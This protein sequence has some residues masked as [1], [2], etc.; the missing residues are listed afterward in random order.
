MTINSGP[1][2]YEA[3]YHTPRGAWV[4]AAE[5]SLMM[6]LLR[7]VTGRTLL[8]VGCG[9]GWF[10]RRFSENGLHVTGVDPDLDAIEFARSQGGNVDCVAGSAID[11]PFGDN[12]FDYCAAVTSLCFIDDA[13]QAVRE[14]WR[15]SRH[16]MVLGL[17]N[18]RSFLC[19][20][21]Q[22]RGGYAGARWDTV[23]DVT[24]WANHLHPVPYLKSGY[25][26]FLPGGDPPARVTEKIV[27]SFIPFGGFMA[28]VLTSAPA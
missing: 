18:R 10:S 21:K 3:W 20:Q 17:L 1:A 27:P 11:L 14:M 24:A 15:V 8:D 28:V 4:G 7:P 22:G 6:S 16:G 9:S 13:K 2:D 5:F 23:A 25:A 12:A 19:R 26:V